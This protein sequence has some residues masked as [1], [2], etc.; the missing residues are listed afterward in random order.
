[1][2]EE[3]NVYRLLV[4]EPEGKKLLGR[5]RYSWVDNIKM[6]LGE[7]EWGGMDWTDLD[8]VRDQW[9]TLVNTAMNLQVP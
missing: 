1:M 6:D 5:Q 7:I 8:Q 3:R 2:G 4:G 9:R